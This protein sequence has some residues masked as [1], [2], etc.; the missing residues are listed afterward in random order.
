MN[1]IRIFIADDHQ[2]I[3][4]GLASLIRGIDGFTLQGAAST[5]EGLI[6]ALS[7]SHTLPDVCVM[8]IEM[9]GMGGLAAL[10]TMKEKFP[11]MKVLMLTMHEE[12]FY[13]NRAVREGADGYLLKNLNREA[14]AES[15]RKIMNGESFFV[16]GTAKVSPSAPSDEHAPDV[17]TVREKHILKLIAQGKSNK[18]IAKELF[19]SNRT[20]D[21]HRNNLMRKLKISSSVQLVHYAYANNLV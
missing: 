14:F 11:T 5:G 6:A 12:P 1:P 16:Q 10:K 8:D 7:N 21:T 9:P 15:V 4:E 20:V 3:L 19:I 2:L 13:V 18:Q 17:L